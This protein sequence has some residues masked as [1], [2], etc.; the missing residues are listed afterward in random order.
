MIVDGTFTC[1]FDRLPFDVGKTVLELRQEIM[2]RSGW[3]DF[4]LAARA[5]TE[6]TEF[7]IYDQDTFQDAVAPDESMCLVTFSE[8]SLYLLCTILQ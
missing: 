3:D 7:C 2:T 4:Q 1:R 8:N 5:G 6:G